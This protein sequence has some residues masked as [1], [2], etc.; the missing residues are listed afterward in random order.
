MAGR[1][2]KVETPVN[3]KGTGEEYQHY[4]RFLVMVN[5]KDVENDNYSSGFGPTTVSVNVAEMIK[6]TIKIDPETAETLNKAQE[7]QNKTANGK[8]TIQ[9]LF[10]A[11][12]V[13]SGETYEAKDVWKAK[14]IRGIEISTTKIGR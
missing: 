4:D 6:G 3:L 13:N 7:H 8:P 1:P 11:G 12:Q 10:P 2:K 9:W 14:K 5:R